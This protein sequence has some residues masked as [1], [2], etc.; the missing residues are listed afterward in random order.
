MSVDDDVALFGNGREWRRVVGVG[1]AAPFRGGRE[2]RSEDEDAVPFGNGAWRSRA[3]PMLF[4]KGREQPE[5]YIFDVKL[6][7][8]PP[9][10]TTFSKRWYEA[11]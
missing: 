3:G 5:R 10:H 1:A 9:S 11:P 4:G 2:W 7:H 8:Y 6:Q